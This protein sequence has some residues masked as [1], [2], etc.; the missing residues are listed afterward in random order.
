MIARQLRGARWAVGLV[1]GGAV[2]LL[3]LLLWWANLFV[4]ARLSLSNLFYVAEEAPDDV[5]LVGIDNATLQAYGTLTSWNR[6]RYADL[7]ETLTEA[8]ARVIVFDLLFAEPSAGDEAF[9]QAVQRARDAGTPTILAVNGTGRVPSD[10]PRVVYR[11][12]LRPVGPLADAASHL[13]YVNAYPDADGTVRT[14]MSLG[15]VVGEP[16]RISLPLAA[17]LAYFRV[18]A[19]LVGSVLTVDEAGISLPPDVTIPTV[20]DGLWYPNYYGT[21]ARNRA[22][23]EVSFRDVPN[24]PPGVFAD[25]IV[26][27]GLT[28]VTGAVDR[29]PAPSTRIG[30]MIPGVEL[31]AHAL[32][33]LLDG[34]ALSPQGRLS[35]V[36][37]FAGLA[38]LTALVCA[39]LRWYGMVAAGVVF[40]AAWGVGASA[41][42]TGAHIIPNALH[43]PLA[44]ALAVLGSI[45]ARISLEVISRTRAERALKS[46]VTMS[47]QRLDIDRIIPLLAEDTRTMTGAA[48]GGVWIRSGDEGEGLASNMTWGGL[49]ADDH[50][51]FC[52]ASFESGKLQQQ[53][54]LAAVPVCWQGA[55]LGV[56]LVSGRRAV[57]AVPQLER[58]AGRIAA[59][60]DNALLYTQTQRQN[61]L[62]VSVLEESPAGIFVLDGQLNLL[63]CNESAA[64]WL[65][66]DMA[67][68]FGKPVSALLANSPM[69]E[70]TWR[71][72]DS[73]L[74]AHGPFRMELTLAGRTLQLDAAHMNDGRWVVTMGDITDLA[75]LDKLKTRMI[76]MASHDLKNPIGRVIGYAELMED[77]LEDN[78]IKEQYSHYTDRIVRSAHEML[79]LITDIL[80]LEHIRSGRAQHEPI[81]ML[82]LVR[83]VIQRHT[84]DMDEREQRFDAKLPETLP[85][86]NGDYNQLVQAVS[87]IL[88]NASKYTPPGGHI[89]LLICRRD[90]K[91]RLE[92]R[93]DGYGM[94]KDAQEKLFTEFYR[95][96][97]EKTMQIEGTG[98]GL[99]LV[100]SVVEAHGG[101]IWVESELDR[102][103]TFFI[104]LPLVNTPAA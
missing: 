102:G 59:S 95:V 21:V 16:E 82:N 52:R 50:E 47:E 88:G 27:V 70:K 89:S 104:E 6:A 42:F 12:E 99:S 81:D 25:K 34:T 56:L 100:K 3:V 94:P 85:T 7:V 73:Q 15:A 57:A 84:D 79:G 71:T 37:T 67:G 13:A 38:F 91:I 55:V 30:E 32:A 11:G 46:L 24:T 4:G 44:V 96:R 23:E 18:S 39:Y 28:D 80:D 93:D 66:L 8:E 83:D 45:G 60:L 19:S 9:A 103:S 49:H 1:V 58:F 92:V 69:D 20:D 65:G 33:S 98:L 76:R 31:Q 74:T 43:P 5:V 87:N 77:L 17:Y 14:N 72:I 53:S 68:D 41:A 29:Y 97:T 2:T 90:D 36:L 26:L 101:K 64:Q 62:L 10:E 86:F 78:G 51:A 35:Q 63:R 75:E 61:Q 48:A 54:E 22:F 40:T